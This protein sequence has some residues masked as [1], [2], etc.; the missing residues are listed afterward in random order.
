M[1]KVYLPSLTLLLVFF[2]SCD[3]GSEKEPEPL[4]VPVV[5][6]VAPTIAQ[7]T[8]ENSVK[9]LTT[10]SYVG[11]NA[12]EEVTDFGF[13]YS[14][15]ST[16]DLKSGTSVSLASSRPFRIAKNTNIEK[17][18]SG[19]ERGTTYYVRAYIVT[20]KQE[21]QYGDQVSFVTFNGNRFAFGETFPIQKMGMVG[22]L[23]GSN[24]YLGA[25]IVYGDTPAHPAFYK[26][27]IGTNA[28]SEIA[29]YPGKGR[30]RGS[31]F[32]ITTSGYLI[33][34]VNNAETWEYNSTNNQWAQKSDFP[35]STS[36]EQ[37]I[38]FSLGGKGYYGMGA[39]QN[40]FWEFDP[41]DNTNGVDQF[42]KPKGK[43]T[44]LNNFPN[45]SDIRRVTPFWFDNVPYII[46]GYPLKIYKYN[47]QTDAWL[48]VTDFSG[49]SST[50]SLNY[51]AYAYTLGSK[52]YA[53]SPED[54]KIWVY[55]PV[56]G[57]WSEFAQPNNYFHG[58]FVY[59]I[60]D[61]AYIFS[62]GGSVAKYILP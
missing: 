47:R 8:D 23:I 53:V 62:D 26:Y 36:R 12:V 40:D 28:W 10:F 7:V 21:E 51:N 60:N 59:T 29:S 25:G 14:K 13:V 6:N 4:P 44:K 24:F 22:F 33:G 55:D 46:G 2:A 16:P 52:I 18:I 38:A 50:S 42:G 57:N 49:K 15:T 5:F 31:S 34:G 30:F 35:G 54:Y 19:L 17:N 56:G 43:W 27:D 48:F 20:T 39:D 9:L 37:A 61:I 58:S 45:T 1:K 3:N 41:T 11:S 32:T